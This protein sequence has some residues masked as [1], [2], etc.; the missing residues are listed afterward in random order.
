MDWNRGSD[1]STEARD[2]DIATDRSTDPDSGPDPDFEVAFQNLVIDLPGKI[3]R[4][5][6]N[7]LKLA[8]TLLYLSEVYNQFGVNNT[9]IDGVPLPT[10]DEYRAI[11]LILEAETSGN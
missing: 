10:P 1:L 4:H 6:N 7:A 8:Y 9:T 3:E 5:P 11:V 2:I